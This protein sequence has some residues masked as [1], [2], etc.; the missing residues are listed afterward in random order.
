M[1]CT[2]ESLEKLK[3]SWKLVVNIENYYSVDKKGVVN[4]SLIIYLQ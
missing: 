4:H 2:P 1:H 3:I